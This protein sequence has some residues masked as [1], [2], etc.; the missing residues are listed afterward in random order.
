MTNILDEI[1]ENTQQ[2]IIKKKEQISEN[3]LLMFVSDNDR[4]FKKALDEKISNKQ[5]ALIAELKKASPSKGLIREHFNPSE[6]SIA[7]KKGGATCLS[8]LTDEKYFQGKDEYIRQVKNSVDLPILR[9]DFMIDMYQVVESRA[10]GANCILI[11]MAAVSDKLAVDLVQS[12]RNFGMDILVEVHN[13]EELERALKLDNKLIGINNRDL[14]TMNIDLSTTEKLLKYIPS[15]Y[16]VICESGIENNND[17]LR[18]QNSGVYG[19]LV[20]SSLMEK[21]N[22]ELATKKLIEG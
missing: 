4:D 19:F 15:G 22:I 9:K 12:A 13:L 3:S 14:K 18:I 2:H 5:T 10:I 21:D 6:I 16:T 8:V 11:I 7:Y 1:C 17:I 20:G